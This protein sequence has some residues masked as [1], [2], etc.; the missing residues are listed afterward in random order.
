[1]LTK[2]FAPIAIA[3]T[4][5]AGVLAAPVTHAAH[6]DV[7]LLSGTAFFVGPTTLS[8]PS[9]SFAQTAADL[10]LQPLGFDGGDDLDSCVV[11]VGICDAPL[12]V[13]STPALIQQGHSSFVGAAEI[14]RAVQ[15]ELQ[16]NPDAYNAENPLWIFGYSQG[17]TAG[18]IAMAQLA[19]DGV[20]PDALHFV[21]I[22]NPAGEGGA[23]SEREADPSSVDGLLNGFLTPNNAFTTTVYSVPGDPVADASSPSAL[24]LLWEHMMYLG[25]TPDQVA[26]QSVTTDGLITNVGIS[27]DFDPFSTWLNAFGNGLADSSW[28]EGIFYSLVASIYGAFGNIEGFFGDW[29]GIDWGGVED[30]LDFWFPAEA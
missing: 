3:G 9:P 26:D 10:F 28:W 17:A 25:L 18:S 29:L 20:D 16:A 30:T 11:G 7:S 2:V 14:V 27:G 15:A 13:L 5:A 19:H 22:G 21:F 24:G 4:V 23:W 6:I 8:T 12:R 1:M